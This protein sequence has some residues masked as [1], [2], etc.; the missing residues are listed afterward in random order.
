MK[1]LSRS[2]VPW[3]IRE[4][5]MPVNRLSAGRGHEGRLVPAGV[6]HLVRLRRRDTLADGTAWACR[7]CGSKPAVAVL[8]ARFFAARA[9]R[10]ENA[11]SRRLRRLAPTRAATATT[12]HGPPGSWSADSPPGRGAAAMPG[13]ALAWRFAARKRQPARNRRLHSTRRSLSF[14]GGNTPAHCACAQ[15]PRASL[16][17]GTDNP[18]TPHPCAA[19]PGE[20]SAEGTAFSQP[21]PR[22][23]CTSS[24]ATTRQWQL[25]SATRTELHFRSEDRLCGFFARRG[26]CMLN[27]TQ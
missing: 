18:I 20:G 3:T 2:S 12:A 25:H 22:Q 16:L 4:S 7:C 21:P 5:H 8:P 15:L 24:T 14:P 23:V 10:K 9:P 26:N 6:S 13:G 17:W 11:T 19:S 27:C 1:G